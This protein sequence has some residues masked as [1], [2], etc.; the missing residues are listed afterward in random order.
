VA[1]RII[2]WIEIM[3]RQIFFLDIDGQST[4]IVAFTRNAGE[5]LIFFIHGLGCSKDTFCHFW[6]RTVFQ[7]YSALVPDLIGFGESTKPD[8][9]SY[10]ME[11]QALLCSEILNN[12]HYK[13]LHI[14][15]HSM[16]AAV[17]LLLPKKILANVKS[18]TNVEGN[19]VGA[20]CGA[21]SRKIISV[22]PA[23]F[24]SDI[25]PGLKAEFNSFGRGYTAIDATTINS[26]YKSAESLVD[27]SDSNKLL[28]I[29][30][31]LQCPKAYFFG[32]ENTDNPAIKLISDVLKVKIKHSGHFPMNDNPEDFYNLL[33]NFMTRLD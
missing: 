7:D 22:S 10:T 11:A 21:M 3:K 30:L 32:D 19:L 24:A 12:F 14:V 1:L 4:E 31:G 25:L 27:W 29:F 8:N 18:F 6:N 9:F 5:D 28:E 17:A 26:L 15:V 2:T 23:E 20:D 13:N 16:G 33:H